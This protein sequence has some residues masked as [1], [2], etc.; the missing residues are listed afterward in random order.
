MSQLLRIAAT[1]AMAS[2]CAP[3]PQP[4]PEA[5]EPPPVTIRGVDLSSLFPGVDAGNATF[6][7]LNGRSGEM[8]RY[9]GARAARR[10]VPASTFKIPN[11]LIALET[12][13]ASGPD[14][15]IAWDS[16][17]PTDGSFWATSWSGDHSLRS[18][19]Q[20]SVYWYYQKL[21]REIGT[22]RMQAYL[23]QFDYGN[24]SMGGGLDRFWLSGDLRI[25]AN[26]QV[27]FLRRMYDSNLGISAKTTRLMKDMLVL[28]SEG[29]YRL[30]GKTGT[31]NLGS[32]LTLAW[33]VGYVEK[34]GETSFFALN[35]EGEEVWARWGSP[36]SRLQLVRELL[37]A[38]GTL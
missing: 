17:R 12:G 15:L 19:L 10:Y 38:T 2:A 9:N 8:V 29:A 25:S 3:A 31:A 21:A 6:V 34:P 36:S 26:E 18:A 35:M 1:V 37:K 13:V 20:N 22:D 14:H 27:R 24:K 33:L 30:S 16:V 11:S 32:G 23:H 5:T 7:V 4:E 28:E